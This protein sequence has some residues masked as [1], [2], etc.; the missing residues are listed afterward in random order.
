MFKKCIG[1]I[2]LAIISMFLISGISFAGQWAKTY[3]GVGNDNGSI[4]PIG[5]G[6][7]YLSGFTDSF[8]AGK[9]DGLIAKL[10]ATGGV[11]WAKTFGGSAD[12][13]LSAMDL[14]DGGFFVSGTTESFGAGNPV[15]PNSNI[16]FAK[17]DSAWSPVFEKVLGG[18]ADESGYFKKT[19]D[20]G[21]LFL[22]ESNSYGASASDQDMLLFKITS[23]GGLTWKKAYHYSQTD[24]M[25]DFVELSDGFLASASVED[26]LSTEQNQIYD[27]LLMK[28]NKSTGSVIW[29]KVLSSTGGS[30][31][32]S[33]FYKLSDGNYLLAGGLTTALGTSNIVLIKLTPDGTVLLSKSYGSS[34]PG[35]NASFTNIIKNSD[36]SL[37]VSGHVM[38]LDMTT[39]AMTNSVIVMKLNADLSISWQKKLGGGVISAVISKAG[40]SGII[41]SGFRAASLTGATNALYARLNPTTFSPVW[42]KTFGGAGAEMGFLTKINTNYLLSGYTESF[43]GATT[44]KPNIFGIILDAKGNYANC[45]VKNFTFKVGDPGLA[46]SN[47]ALTTKANVTLTLRAVAAPTAITLKKT[48]PTLA[49]K[50]ICPAIAAPQGETLEESVELQRDAE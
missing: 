22:G 45:N 38:E 4:W 25:N 7:Y 42:A 28:L 29:N 2:S 47:L 15:A 13:Y 11:T 18:A 37:I 40:T 34:T 49:V 43:G 12:D 48:S 46:I 6:T 35:A 33:S 5:D 3:G 10:N 24:S 9:I 32:G 50:N 44:N 20:K 21:F 1:I 14:P 27:I 30:L 39:Y 19:T 26:K 16:V 23:A 41:L 17:F 31:S 36:G 8:G